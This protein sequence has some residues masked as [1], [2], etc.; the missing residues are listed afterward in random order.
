VGVG[1]TDVSASPSG[2]L[3]SKSKQ[4]GGYPLDLRNSPRPLAG[5]AEAREE[6]YTAKGTYTGSLTVRQSSIAQNNLGHI[7]VPC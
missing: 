7:L 1:A 3:L 2:E 6:E 4:L 5:D